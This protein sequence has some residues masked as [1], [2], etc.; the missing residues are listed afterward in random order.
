ML[1]LTAKLKVDMDNMQQ[2]NCSAIVQLY[3]NTVS[4][5]GGPGGVRYLP[6]ADQ[7]G[8]YHVTGSLKIADKNGKMTRLLTPLIKALDL[9]RK[10]FLTLLSRYW[11]KLCCEDPEHHTNYTASSYLPVLG[12]SV[13]RLRDYI[14]DAHSS[15]GRQATSRCCVRTGCWA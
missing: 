2:H 15:R 4:K 3:D 1:D 13:F 5:V 8:N 6:E 14:R 12:V 11:L 7:Y 10:I 9:T